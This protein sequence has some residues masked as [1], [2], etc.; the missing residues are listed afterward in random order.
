MS[1]HTCFCVFLK[2]ER[3]T[4][5]SRPEQRPGPTMQTLNRYMGGCRWH[6]SGHVGGEGGGNKLS[7]FDRC[8]LTCQPG[9]QQPK[10]A[11]NGTQAGVKPA[12]PVPPHTATHTTP[13]TQPKSEKAAFPQKTS[14]ASQTA[15]AWK[16]IKYFPPRGNHVVWGGWR[17]LECRVCLPAS[18]L[19]LDLVLE[20]KIQPGNLREPPPRGNHVGGGN[21]L[22]ISIQ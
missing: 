3:P 1:K 20:T 9:W 18:R 19:Q 22:L 12:P 13:C 16:M 21:I 6:L 4:E 8:P 11:A 5:G 14:P 2:L 17:R 15:R 10:I 7:F